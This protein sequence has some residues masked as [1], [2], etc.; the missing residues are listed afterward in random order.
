ML[1]LS[2][3]ALGAMARSYVFD[4]VVTSWLGDVPLADSVPVDSGTLEF[5]STLRVP[6]RV[7]LRVPREDRGVSWS[8][9]GLDHPLGWW[10]QRLTVAYALQL[11]GGVETIDR[12]EF[13]IVRTASNGDQVD[14]EG[15]G[16]LRWIDEARF[17]TPFQPAGTITATVRKLVEPAL[18]V[19]FEGAPADRSVPGSISWDEDRL[20][21]LHELLDAWGADC[22]VDVDGVLVVESATDPA[23]TPAL[24]FTDGA[25]GTAVAWA[26]EGTREG[27]RSL[28]VA[29]GQDASGAQVQGVAIDG[30][31]EFGIGG[32]FNPL[33]VPEFYFSPLLTTVGQC[34]TAAATILR[35]R[36]RTA[37]R[38]VT[39]T[40]VPH[41]GLELGDL[42]E[43]TSARAKLELAPAVVESLQLPL[44][45]GS[46]P[47]VLSS[48]LVTT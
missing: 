22:H 39:T 19:D 14:V 26:G 36:R 21:A 15:I 20:G 1:D 11:P 9:D 35:R 5:D 43:L 2:A 24:G 16:L 47:M 40:A 8:P 38:R 42:V 7:T 12:G 30:S 33:P 45:A 37:G 27:A 31:P 44:T 17:V 3:T 23:G 48:R 10:G 4:P 25:G 13:V 28:V 18:V 34:R 41:L 46:G 32:P 6:D 29:R